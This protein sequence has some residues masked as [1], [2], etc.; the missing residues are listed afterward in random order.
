MFQ[1]AGKGEGQSCE[2]T[3]GHL[4]MSVL[5]VSGSGM[6][7]TNMFSFGKSKDTVKANKAC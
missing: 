6:K 7:C 2:Q 5:R 4:S 1:V 3:D